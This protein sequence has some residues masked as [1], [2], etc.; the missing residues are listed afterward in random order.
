M[1]GDILAVGASEGM[2]FSG[3]PNGQVYILERDATSGIWV[4]SARLTSEHVE[5][6]VFGAGGDLLF[7]MNVRL[8]DG[9][10]VAPD[11]GANVV[12]NAEGMGRVF[13]YERQ[14]GDL[15]CA[16]QANSASTQGASLSVNGSTNASFGYLTFGLGQLP[17]GTSAILLAARSAGVV[18]VGAGILC[19]G[20]DVARVPGGLLTADAMGTAVLQLGHQDIPMLAPQP[21]EK[22]LFQA[23]YRDV[24]SGGSNLTDSVI[25]EFE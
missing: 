24:G 21:G 7:G 8:S 1:D 4:E 25:V 6:H 17:A 2:T 16:G 9:V 15:V 18:P 10:V 19:L 23:W 13:I 3:Q 22:I 14:V 11:Y 20:S 12:G 5:S